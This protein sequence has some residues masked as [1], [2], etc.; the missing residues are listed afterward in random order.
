LLG[1]G[2]TSL[3]LQ[4]FSD[5]HCKEWR[6]MPRASSTAQV[7]TA[8]VASLLISYCGELNVS[9]QAQQKREGAV[10]YRDT[11]PV[12]VCIAELSYADQAEQPNT[13]SDIHSLYKNMFI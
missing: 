4:Q 2:Q 13:L 1:T 11:L 10:T 6:Q 9:L 12:H 8:T 7:V 5:Q 3:K